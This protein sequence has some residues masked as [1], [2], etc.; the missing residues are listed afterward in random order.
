VLTEHG[1][2]FMEALSAVTPNVRWG[3]E[4]KPPKPKPTTQPD[5]SV[6][7]FADPFAGP[8]AGY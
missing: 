8:D 1:V 4:P 3:R 2:T 5:P 6:G 7:P